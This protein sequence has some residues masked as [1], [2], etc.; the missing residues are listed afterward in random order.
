MLSADV[1]NF[2]EALEKELREKNEDEPAA[3]EEDAKGSSKK[4]EGDTEEDE[5]NTKKD[6]SD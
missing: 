2:A 4:E 5:K 1:C 3:T 6:S